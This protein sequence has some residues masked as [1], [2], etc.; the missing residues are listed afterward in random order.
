MWNYSFL[1]SLQHGCGNF[2]RVIQ[3]YNRT[4]LYV[5]GSG[6]FSPV[7]VYVNRGRRSEVSLFSFYPP[8]L[9]CILL[10]LRKT[11]NFENAKISDPNR[12][13][14]SCCV[15][16][17][18]R[19]I[20]FF[21]LLPARSKAMIKNHASNTIVVQNSTVI[22]NAG[23]HLILLFIW[24]CLVNSFLLFVG[25]FTKKDLKGSSQLDKKQNTQSTFYNFHVLLIPG[26]SPYVG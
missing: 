17:E 22:P 1:Y 26:R 7:C 14:Q 8:V 5:C 20:G 12:F 10:V 2:V 6:A 16:K 11:Q 19:S 13:L 23:L 18:Q 4:H 25:K 15:E 3:S 24:H 9:S 21:D